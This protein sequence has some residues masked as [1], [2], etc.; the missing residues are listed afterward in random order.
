MTF[1]LEPKI[2]LPGIGMVGTENTYRI[3]SKGALC[4]TGGPQELVIILRK[5]LHQSLKNDKMNH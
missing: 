1:A 2:A 3:T 4:L 5:G